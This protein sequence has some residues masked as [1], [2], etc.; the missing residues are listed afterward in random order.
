MFSLPIGILGVR[1]AIK[2]ACVGLIH[3]ELHRQR[4]VQRLRLHRFHLWQ[5]DEVLDTDALRSR[6]HVVAAVF[7]RSRAPC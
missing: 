1:L 2:L 7:G 3:R 6:A 4:G 5:A